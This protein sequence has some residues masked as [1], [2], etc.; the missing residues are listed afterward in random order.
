MKLV[1]FKMVIP[2]LPCGGEDI[3]PGGFRCGGEDIPP[4]GFRGGEDIPPGG[5]RGG[6]DIPPGGFRDERDTYR[7]R[8]GRN[9][10]T[11]DFIKTGGH[12][13]VDIVSQPSYGGRNSGCHETHRLS[14]SRGGK[15][16]C[17][18]RDSAVSTMATAKRYAKSWADNTDTYIKTGRSFG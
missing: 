12:Y 4:G 11:F 1:N 2:S 3:P 5:F 9:T 6:E 18:G 8:D 15:R 17:F 13:E 10:Y 14:S 16:I 7:T